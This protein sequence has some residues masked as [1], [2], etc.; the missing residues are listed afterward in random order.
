MVCPEQSV[1]F[2]LKIVGI[3]DEVLDVIVP[4]ILKPLDELLVV[5]SF[6]CSVLLSEVADEANDGCESCGG[7]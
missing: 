6:L 7:C 4:M 5:Q 1:D 3:G 2:V